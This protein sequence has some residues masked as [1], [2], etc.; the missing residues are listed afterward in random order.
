MWQAGVT[1]SGMAPNRTF[2]ASRRLELCHARCVTRKSPTMGPFMARPC[3]RDFPRE[4]LM[5]V[6]TTVVV[7]LCVRSAAAITRRGW[8]RGEKNVP[9]RIN[10][11]SMPT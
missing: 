7:R 9:Y 11:A 10:T 6:N 2:Y 1:P 5:H 3:V 8:F 4:E